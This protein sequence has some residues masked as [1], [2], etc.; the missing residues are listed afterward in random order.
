MNT[1]IDIPF[2]AFRDRLMIVNVVVLVDGRAASPESRPPRARRGAAVQHGR[3]A[4]TEMQ[5]PTP[6][7]RLG[8]FPRIVAV[9]SSPVSS[10]LGVLSLL[11]SSRN[12][13]VFAAAIVFL[14]WFAL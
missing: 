13:F 1:T 11:S 12:F 6:K 4:R 5:A 10:G 9:Q 3:D 7:G 2:Q 14:F 8:K